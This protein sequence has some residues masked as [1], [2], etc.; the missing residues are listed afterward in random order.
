MAERARGGET[1]DVV[2]QDVSAGRQ[3]RG[4]SGLK[5]TMAFSAYKVIVIR[6]HLTQNHS[7]VAAYLVAVRGLM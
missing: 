2:S 3:S 7:H 1:Q 4:T 6:T 5:E